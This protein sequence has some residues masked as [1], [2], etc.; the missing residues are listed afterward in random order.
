MELDLLFCY[1]TGKSDLGRLLLVSEGKIT[2]VLRLDY[3]TDQQD[4]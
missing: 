2:V 3:R 4:R 1:G